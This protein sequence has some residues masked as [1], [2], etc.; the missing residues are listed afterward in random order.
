MEKLTFQ[1]PGISCGHC[2][3]SI[4]MELGEL[5]GVDS[6]KGDVASKKVV[7]EFQPPATEQQMVELMSEINYPVNMS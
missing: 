2:V 1:V 4:E 5:A 7:V 6:V 3:N